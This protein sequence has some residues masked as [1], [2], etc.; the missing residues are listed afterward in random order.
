MMEKI[1]VVDDERLNINVLN[2]LLKNEYKV[3]AAVNGEQALKAAR[4]KNKPDLILLDIMMPNIDGYEVCRRL[5]EDENTKD[6]PVIFISAKGQDAD[7]M[8]GFRLGAVDYITKPISPPI[9]LTRV[10]TQLKIQRAQRELEEAYKVIEKQKVRM[11]DELNIGKNIQLS[12]L[13]TAFPTNEEIDL[14]AIMDAAREVGGDFYDF[15]FVDEDNICICVG[16]VSGKGVPASLFMAITTSMIK[17]RGADDLSTASI[18]T[19]VNNEVCMNNESSMFVTIFLAIINIR[20]GEMRYTNAGHNPPYIKRADGKLEKLSKRHGPVIGALDGMAYSEDVEIISKGDLVFM[21]TDG[22]TEALNN[23]DELYGDI[24]LENVLMEKDIDSSHNIVKNVR[25]SVEEFE[26]DVEQTDD[27]TILSLKYN[28]FINKTKE[29]FEI[30]IE[31]RVDEM[32]RFMDSLDQFCENST[33]PKKIIPKLSVIF[34]EMLNN[35]ISYGYVDDK[36]HE[37]IIKVEILNDRLKVE[38]IDD[39][40]PFNPLNLADPDITS[41][42]E[43]R[44]IGGLGIHFTKQFSDKI[45]YRRGVNRNILNIIKMI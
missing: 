22:V 28:G 42:I 43:D 44:E 31:N 29:N 8:E 20:S 26:K 6:I 11:E 14:Y 27:V 12:M 23:Q 41:S 33:L 19:H 18:L 1:L 21:F 37:I 30:K 39:G 7:E 40:I 10:K 45:Y 5:K 32:N 3:M 34:D 16:D 36:V 9:V 15:F 25:K 38:I 13:P 17:S 35:I 2:D 4:S 24:R